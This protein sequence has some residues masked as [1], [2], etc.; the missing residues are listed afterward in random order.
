MDSDTSVA[1]T[2][3]SA[4]E[5]KRMLTAAGARVIVLPAER[6]ADDDD[7]VLLTRKTDM[8]VSLEALFKKLGESGIDSILVEGGSKVHSSLF[9]RPDLVS[10]VYAYLSPKLIGKGL[11]PINSEAVPLELSDT[12][13]IHLGN[14][15]CITGRIM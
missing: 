5:K 9:S 6:P 2:S 14:D 3:M 15:I 4:T 12:E 8:R 11:P 1:D 7:S 13:L 10:R